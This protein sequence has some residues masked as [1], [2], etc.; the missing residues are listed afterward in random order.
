M[1]PGDILTLDIA[2]VNSEGE[3][4]A[5]FGEDAFVLFIPGV[6]PGEKVTCRVTR[7]NKKYAAGVPLNILSPSNDRVMP[8]CPS[9][10]ACGGCQLQHASYDA[11]LRI[12]GKMLQDAL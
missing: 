2:S 7:V 8:K 10:D 6:L 11:Q 5:R 1:N 4:V 9:F 3:G 12:K